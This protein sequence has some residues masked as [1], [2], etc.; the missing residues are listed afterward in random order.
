MENSSAPA[1]GN[2]TGKG[3]CAKIAVPPEGH[4]APFFAVLVPSTVGCIFTSSS[5][6]CLEAV[7]GPWLGRGT[8]PMSLRCRHECRSMMSIACRQAGRSVGRQ[9]GRSASRQ[10]GR[11]ATQQVG[12]SRVGTVH[13][14]K[15][16]DRRVGESAGRQA[17]RQIGSSAGRQVGRHSVHQLYNHL[18]RF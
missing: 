11:S 14:G 1:R 3:K 2:S 12:R 6:P 8:V 16:E 18:D 17:G 5:A 4:P 15:S 10:V 13:V 9:V 7:L